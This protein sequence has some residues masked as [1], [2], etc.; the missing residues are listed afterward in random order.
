[1]SD[2]CTVLSHSVVS[3]SWLWVCLYVC[4]WVCLH[5]RVHLSQSASFWD[6]PNKEMKALFSIR[7]FTAHLSAPSVHHSEPGIPNSALGVR[8]LW[9]IQ[10]E[11]SLE[12]RGEPRCLEVSSY[13]FSLSHSQLALKDIH[14]LVD[15]MKGSLVRVSQKP[16][17][18]VDISYLWKCKA[19]DVG[20]RVLLRTEL[21]FPSFSRKK[22]FWKLADSWD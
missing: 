8:R 18:E 21:S 9:E 11:A 7:I 3:N 4:V 12:C 17:C 13:S 20:H 1:M 16:E 22:R 5:S 14:V 2:C 6:I 19:K 15:R 10:S